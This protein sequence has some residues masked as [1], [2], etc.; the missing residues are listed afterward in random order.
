MVSKFL[1][2][3][4]ALVLLFCMMTDVVQAGAR[5]STP[6]TITT[7]EYLATPPVV[8]T[9]IPIPLLAPPDPTPNPPH[10]LGRAAD[11]VLVSPWRLPEP[12]VIIGA[13]WLLTV[14]IFLA[15][16]ARQP[17]RRALGLPP[18][19]VTTLVYLFGVATVALLAYLVFP[20]LASGV[21]A[22]LPTPVSAGGTILLVVLLAAKELIPATGRTGKTLLRGLN[23]VLL[24]LW[25]LFLIMVVSRL[26]TLIQF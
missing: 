12:L 15:S 19:L 21:L 6:V 25:T 22:K 8:V 5:L 1:R 9:A 16:S 10:A 24:P 2:G 26:L 18:L 14:V 23:M 17:Q 11:N 3:W 4:L 7:T 13:L 20:A